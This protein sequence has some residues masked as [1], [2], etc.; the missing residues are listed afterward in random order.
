MRFEFATSTRIVFGPGTM[1]EVVPLVAEMGKRA[2][3]VVGRT[4]ERAAPLL[5]RLNK[6]GIESVTYHVVGEPTITTA[7][8]G[9][10]LARRSGCDSVV[11]IGGGSVLDTGKVVAA[12]LTNRGE[13]MDYLEVIG[14]GQKLAERPAPYTA[15]PTTAGTGAEVTRNAVLTSPE[16][17]VKVS[18]R[19]PLMLPR[20]AVVDPALT[21]SMPPAVT[22]STGLDAFTQLMEAFVS[23]QANPLTDALCRE[24]LRRAASSLQRAYEDGSNTG[25]REDMSLAS[26]FSGMALANAKL[27]AV[28]GLAGPLGGLL[29]APHGAICARLLPYVMEANVRC[30]Q[31][32]GSDSQGLARYREIARILTGRDTAE[33]GE[34]VRWV[35]D[36]TVRLKVPGLSELGLREKDFPI[37]VERSQ[38]ASSMRGNP[39]PLRDSELEEILRRAL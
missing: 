3:V 5:E 13:L 27:G 37:V 34:G 19:S 31:I 18:M 4:L 36:L 16:E 28:H 11:G 14:R 35:K 39:L 38:K 20:L 29:G 21:C 10:E 7:H 8:A 12:L 2:L 30:L 24:G 1:E 26:L 33:V 25:A 23:I 6:G 15:I 32:R 22:A 9:V 17:R